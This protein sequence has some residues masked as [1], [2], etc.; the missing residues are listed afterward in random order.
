[1]V[2]ALKHWE[3]YLVQR[4]FVLYSDHQALKFINSQKKLD[5]IHVW[6]STF[7]KKIMFTIK[8]RSGSLNQVANALSRRASLLVTFSQ[9]IVGFEYLKELYKGDDNCHTRTSILYLITI[10]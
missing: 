9:E 5:N 4:E 8:H 10:F 2:R 3:N 6:W 1:M 7:L